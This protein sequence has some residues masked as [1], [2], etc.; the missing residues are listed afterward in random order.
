MLAQRFNVFGNNML[1]MD[2]PGHARLRNLVQKAFTPAL[3]Q[4]LHGRIEQITEACI[5]KSPIHLPLLSTHPKKKALVPLVGLETGSVRMAKQVMPSKGVP[6]PIEEWQSVFIRGLEVM[7]KHNWFPAAT[8]I[9]GN[10]GET[11]EDFAETRDLFEACDFDMAYVFK[12]SIRTGTP[13]AE[14]GDQVPEGVKEERNR[15]LLGILERNSLRRTAALVGT[16][17][18]VLVDGPDKTGT[19]F[20]GR[21]RGN[22][23]CVFDADP[24][25]VGALVP[26]H[27][28]Y[29]AVST[30]LIGVESWRPRT[31][32]GPEMIHGMVLSTAVPAV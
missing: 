12:Y 27:P 11:D 2:D 20:T 3:V 22:R 1:G 9:V 17:E 23:V 32:P 8:L 15:I 26:D 21:T 14:L 18:E 13:A 29:A 10:P 4:N 25:L 31:I 7:N 30:V 5:D 16:V 24:R 6:F 19:R 28:R